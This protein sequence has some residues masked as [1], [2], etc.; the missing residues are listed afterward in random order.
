MT[1]RFA[2]Y[3]PASSDGSDPNLALDPELALCIAM[4]E[5]E[6]V[7]YD[8]FQ[9]E[10]DYSNGDTRTESSA[11]Q[12]LV[13]LA[14]HERFDYVCAVSPYRLAKRPWVCSLIQ[15]ALKPYGGTL[16][17]VESAKEEDDGSFVLEFREF[18]CEAHV[19]GLDN[20]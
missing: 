5:E 1:P 16:L 12:R 9:E 3:C 14:K 20:D 17:L 19:K 11:L 6:G 18:C 13:E 2:L 7:A 8:V 10:Q 4:C 15:D